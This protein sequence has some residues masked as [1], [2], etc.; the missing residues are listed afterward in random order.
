M[1]S[2][3]H[4]SCSVPQGSVVGLQLFILY[5]ADLADKAEEHYVTV[6]AFA[7]DPQLYLHCRREDMTPTI[8]RLEHCISDFGHCMSANRLKLN[9]DKTELLRAGTW[10]ASLGSRGPSLQLDANTTSASDDIRVLSVT[11]SSDLSLEKHVTNIVQLASTSYVNF[12]ESDVPS[13][14]SQLRCSCMPSWHSALTIAMCCWPALQRLWQTSSNVSS[15][16]LLVL[17]AAHGNLTAA[18]PQSVILS[19]TGLKFLS[20]SFTSLVSL[21]TDAST[22]KHNNTRQTAAHQCLTFL[23]DNIYG[24]P[25]II[26]LMSH[27]TG[28]AHTADGLSLSPARL[29]GTLYRSSSGIRTLA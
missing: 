21:R 12:D 25:V 28:W 7:D 18:C 10:H 13:T 4:I 11:T 27:N 23:L 2:T 24:P 9:M 29:C 16:L 14:S 3:V 22:E 6:H 8:K 17:L 15:T 19:C 26:I 20:R 1:S 5:T